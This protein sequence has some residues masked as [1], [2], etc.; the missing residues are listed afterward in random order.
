MDSRLLDMKNRI[1]RINE[2]LSENDLKCEIGS[3]LKVLRT[4]YNL[5][6]KEVSEMLEIKPSSYS[7]YETGASTPKAK[8]IILLSAMYNVTSD[9]ILGINND[10]DVVEISSIS[11][12]EKYEAIQDFKEEI[13]EIKLKMKDFEEWIE[14]SKG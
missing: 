12:I 14:K 4:K 11:D 2:K 7:S 10:Y 8:T 13:Q 3:R 6:Q 9:Y 1:N 5:E